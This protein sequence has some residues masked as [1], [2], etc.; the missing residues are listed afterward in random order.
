[1]PLSKSKVR[2]LTTD[3]EWTLLEAT[4]RAP[5]AEA[6]PVQLRKAL[7]RLRK[8]ADKYRDLAHQQGGEARGK[9]R[10][11]KTRPAQGHANTLAKHEVFAEALARVAAEVAK[12]DAILARDAARE[13][14]ALAKAAAMAERTAQRAS[15]A[16][17]RAALAATSMSRKAKSASTRGARKAAT[18]AKQSTAAHQAHGAARGRRRQAKRDSRN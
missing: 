12:R 2:A 4:F 14:K 10:A 13:A 17:S 18:W 1:M 8:A 11:K 5:L 6:T 16:E 3:S 15:A 7:T 9:R